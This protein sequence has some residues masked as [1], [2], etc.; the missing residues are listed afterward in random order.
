MDDP[1]SLTPL[2]ATTNSIRREIRGFVKFER[3]IY[4]KSTIGILAALGLEDEEIFKIVRGGRSGLSNDKDWLSARPR[5]VWCPV[6]GFLISRISRLD[7]A[8][9]QGRRILVEFYAESLYITTSQVITALRF[10]QKAIAIFLLKKAWK[11]GNP[12]LQAAFSP[13]ISAD[14]GD[15]SSPQITD[16]SP[17]SAYTAFIDPTPEFLDSFCTTRTFDAWSIIKTFIP[18]DH[19]HGVYSIR[20]GEQEEEVTTA[21]LL[22][23]ITMTTDTEFAREALFNLPVCCCLGVL[24]L[25]FAAGG[26][27]LESDQP[28]YD[29]PGLLSMHPNLLIMLDVIAERLHGHVAYDKFPVHLLSLTQS[30]K[31]E[32]LTLDIQ[33]CRELLQKWP[34]F[35]G[36]AGIP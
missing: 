11:S 17:H 16:D 24:Q 10:K 2:A 4:S 3:H 20:V 27:I 26:W 35:M 6:D 21:R 36:R 15:N 25:L 8:I 1:Y 32:K 22:L 30:L 31:V 9:I 29:F 7:L 23:H 34:V 19:R 5:L 33:G 28:E 14:T 18:D 12:K 13:Y